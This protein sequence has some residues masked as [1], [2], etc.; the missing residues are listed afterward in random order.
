[1]AEGA[2]GYDCDAGRDAA[3]NGIAAQKRASNH[4]HLLRILM[5]RARRVRIDNHVQPLDNCATE[6]ERPFSLARS[7]PHQVDDS[8]VF[9]CHCETRHV[10]EIR[11]RCSCPTQVCVLFGR[12]LSEQSYVCSIMCTYGVHQGT[13]TYHRLSSTS[14]ITIQ[15][16]ACF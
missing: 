14:M 1:M 15:L 12:V 5:A 9:L 6:L 2:H 7:R 4:V 11:L 16:L 3:M 10:R 13:E 8:C